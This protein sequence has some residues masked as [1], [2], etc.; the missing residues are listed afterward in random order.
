MARILFL[1]F[2]GGGNLPPSLGIARELT[3]RGHDVVFVG[4]PEMMPRMKPTRFRAIELTQAYAQLDKYPPHPQFGPWFCGL[5]SPAIE[6]QARAIVDAEKPDFVLVDFM[7]LAANKLH[8]SQPSAAMA[9]MAFNH[10]SDVFRGLAQMTSGIRQQSGF[11]PLPDFDSLMLGRDRII[12]TSLGAIDPTPAAS[13]LARLIRHVG[14]AL[15]TEAHVQPLK[16]PYGWKASVPLVLV[17]FSTDPLQATPELIQRTISAL[18]KLKVNAVATVGAS[19]DIAKLSCPLNVLVVDAAN[20]DLLLAQASLVIT[21]GGH[22]TVMRSL[23]HGVPLIVM[24][25]VAPDQAPNGQMVEDLGAGRVLAQDAAGEAIGALTY[26]VLTTASYHTR[27]KAIAKQ[28]S[29]IDGAVGAADEVEA[30][31]ARGAAGAE[32]AA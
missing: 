29:G 30:L 1:A 8:F 5:T 25:G 3:S 14:P 4:D 17:S 10:V 31:L 13:P 12:V 18:G 27:A 7:F 24:P 16:L 2:S 11:E 22:G 19:L 26:E 23:K 21:H 9:H 20:H 28:F 32:A 6:A 15:E